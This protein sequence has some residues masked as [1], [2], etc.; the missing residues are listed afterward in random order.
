MANKALLVGINDYKQ[1]NDLRGCLNDLNWKFCYGLI[2]VSLSIGYM[3]TILV[4]FTSLCLLDG[5]S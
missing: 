3:L 2:C 4:F 1:I 5:T